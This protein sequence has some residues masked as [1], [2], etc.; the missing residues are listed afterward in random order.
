MPS[1]PNP[2]MLFDIIESSHIDAGRTLMIGDSTWD[3]NDA[4]KAGVDSVGITKGTHLCKELERHSPVVCIN[5][6]MEL[7]E[8]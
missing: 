3:L 2:S 5:R 8:G 1:K 4:N 6:L 7:I